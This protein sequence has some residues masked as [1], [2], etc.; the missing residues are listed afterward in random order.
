[1]S[2][3]FVIVLPLLLGLGSLEC[4]SKSKPAAP[5]SPIGVYQ[6]SGYDKAGKKIVEGLL[7]ITSIESNYLKGTWQ[8]KPI[9]NPDKIGPQVGTGTFVG[10]LDK[11][12]VRI[13]LN[14]NMADNNVTLAGKIEGARFHGA[15]S[16]SGFAG[17]ISQGTFE[18]RKK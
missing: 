12:S 10:D 18:A 15:W 6:Y 8:L 2:K 14:P 5:A 11:D 9:G 4:D 17:V 1:M 16:Y 13:N 3:V 7:E